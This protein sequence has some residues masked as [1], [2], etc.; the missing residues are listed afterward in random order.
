MPVKI[1]STVSGIALILALVGVIEWRL[2][3]FIIG[4]CVVYITLMAISNRKNIS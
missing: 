2:F 3:G 1:A 4:G